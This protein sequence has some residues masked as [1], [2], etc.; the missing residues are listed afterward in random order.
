MATG[1]QMVM[2]PGPGEVARVLAAFAAF[3]ES[4]AVPAEARRAILVVLDELLTNIASYGM[5]G[6]ADGRATVE[7]VVSP[8]ALE[9]TLTDNGPHF[10]PLARPAPDTTLSVEDRP[11]GGMGIFLVRHLVD[12]ARYA[13]TLNQNVLVITKRLPAGASPEL[14]GGA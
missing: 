11:I 8:D 9:V 1:F 4:R 5:E 12:D 14:E 3:V 7:V 13:R 10:D 2:G 6:Q